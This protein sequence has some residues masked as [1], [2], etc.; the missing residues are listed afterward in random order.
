[1]LVSTVHCVVYRDIIVR[2]AVREDAKAIESLIE[3]LTHKDNLLTD[4][5]QYFAARRDPVSNAIR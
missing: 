3:T 4:L 5:S 1:M 2:D